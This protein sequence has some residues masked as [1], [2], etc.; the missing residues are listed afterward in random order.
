MLFVAEEYTNGNDFTITVP[1]SYGYYERSWALYD[2]K[3]PLFSV[4]GVHDDA[5]WS[6]SNLHYGTLTA[7]QLLPDTPHAIR[8]DNDDNA[9]GV[10]VITYRVP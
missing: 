10:L 3:N 9:Y 1:S 5:I 4:D 7:S 6:G 2:V 8:V